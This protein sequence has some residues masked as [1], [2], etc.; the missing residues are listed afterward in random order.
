MSDREIYLSQNT[1]MV[2]ESDEARLACDNYDSQQITSILK[3][4]C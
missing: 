1:F 3:K 2:N 4:H